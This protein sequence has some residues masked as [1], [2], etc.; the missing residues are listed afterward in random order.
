MNKTDWL[1]ITIKGDPLGKM[2]GSVFRKQNLL[3]KFKNHLRLKVQIV[4]NL[5]NH[6]HS[7]LW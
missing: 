6:E 3:R 7:T 4:D 5:S 2:Q 1:I